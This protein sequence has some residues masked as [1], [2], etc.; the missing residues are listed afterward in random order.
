MSSSFPHASH[1]YARGIGGHL[2]SHTLERTSNVPFVA[3]LTGAQ[4]PQAFT[5]LLNEGKG[6][7]AALALALA[8]AMAL[9]RV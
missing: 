9:R 8:L 2:E 3:M 4:G 5:E 1:R 6:L 7:N